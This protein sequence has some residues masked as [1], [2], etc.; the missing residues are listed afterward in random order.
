MRKTLNILFGACVFL[1]MTGCADTIDPPAESRAD[2]GAGRVI[3]TLEGVGQSART[4]LPADP[5][6]TAYDVKFS[7]EG[8]DDSSYSAIPAGELN[9]KQFI[10]DAGSWNVEVT[11][12]RIRGETVYAAASGVAVLAVEA[13]EIKTAQVELKPLAAGTGFF[14]Y[15]IVPPSGAGSAALVL[16]AG[17]E[18]KVNKDLKSGASGVEELE[19]GFYDLFL[20]MEKDGD[21]RGEYHAVHIYG[22]LATELGG[23][24][25]PY[26]LSGLM[27]VS[28]TP[29]ADNLSVA[30]RNG[31]SA[32]FTLTSA[33]TGGTWKVYGAATGE[34]ESE[35]VSASFASE[36]K[37]L[38]L[39]KEGGVPDGDYWVAVAEQ[40]KIESARLKLTVN[41]VE[42]QLLIYNEGTPA[43]GTST[44]IPAL[45]GDNSYEI[46]NKNAD[47]LY[48]QT[49]ANNTGYT[50][51]YLNTPLTGEMSIRARVKITANNIGGTSG[52]NGVFTG[53]LTDPTVAPLK[54][55][56]I[57]NGLNNAQ[58]MYISRTGGDNSSS[59][60]NTSSYDTEFIYEV[61][62]TGSG[63][64]LTLYDS[65]APNAQVATGTRGSGQNVVTELV[66]TSSPVYAGFIIS[67]VDV[68]ISNIVI[69]E[70]AETVYHTP[71]LV[72]EV[73]I[74]TANPVG[75]DAEYDYQTP[76]ASFPNG[77][78]QLSAAIEPEDADDKSLVWS[79]DD[80][81]NY[82]N[83]TTEGLVSF[84]GTGTATVRATAVSGATGV[85][86]FN[87]TDDPP[88][89]VE[90]VTVSGESAVD[91][92]E[93][94]AGYPTI[95][96]TAKVLPETAIPGVTWSVSLSNI[97]QSD[98]SAYAEISGGVLTA[99]QAGTVYVYATSVG[100]DEQ[101]QSVT[102]E[103]F[104]VIINPYPAVTGVAITS[105]VNTVAIGKKITLAASVTPSENQQGVT[106][107]LTAGGGGDGS[108]IAT[109][110]ESTGVL[111]GVSAGTV[112]V[113][114]TSVGKNNQAQ[115]VISAPF[116]VT[117]EEYDP[118]IFYWD[119][120]ETPWT[121]VAA[122]AT[123]TMGD[124]STPFRGI[125]K[126][127][128][129]DN[130]GIS[131]TQAQLV[132]GSNSTTNTTSSSAPS[133]TL[134]FSKRL[135]MTISVA[136]LSGTKNLQIFV[137][138]N[139]TS[140]GNSP[141]ES[142]SRIYNAAPS[143]E[144]DLVVEF[145]PS[146]YTGAEEYLKEGFFQFR[147]ESSMTV[148]ITKIEL[149][150]VD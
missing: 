133:G 44:A 67:G 150:Y 31:K 19:A 69:K 108:S 142:K 20:T 15:N 73:T 50:V 64:T 144:A 109:I 1:F 87:I 23:E 29:A 58:T 33:H 14:T 118:V 101:S 37:A 89:A 17:D 95:T 82:A 54:F 41:V 65:E 55:V 141:L 121:E 105:S 49:W 53:A 136:S 110:V 47:A 137:L 11:G 127:I 86:K 62:R 68:E 107:S 79:I 45:T 96:L 43:E 40:S 123:G 13:G 128:T 75:A 92:L 93:P 143:V 70:G 26:D 57:R 52:N 48:G 60:L 76:L 129:S 8:F 7:R 90:S 104:A 36:T 56:G 28:K 71:I 111:L 131:I 32:V 5:V 94:G 91:L 21:I 34:Q 12:Y 115:T 139:T 138:N 4:L 84:T 10:L 134:D 122:G 88:P 46:S 27:F 16:K 78:V 148:V 113:Y 6:F 25:N 83:V 99:K 130:G 24:D 80:T 72:S 30:I 9:G 2:G 59:G 77:G 132:I 42:P 146:S 147:T 126:A 102:S 38:T 98:A 119:A 116:E 125:N 66:S 22:G 120:A 18:E 103:P 74:S 106:W 81:P 140:A 114:A 35:G 85:F 117:I 112:L 61:A 39:S 149:K 135:K 100:K 145:D 124:P 51:V 97:E 63:Y 3:L